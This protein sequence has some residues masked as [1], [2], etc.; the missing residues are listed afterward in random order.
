MRFKKI[1]TGKLDEISV[2]Y[3]VLR[4]DASTGETVRR[5]KSDFMKSDV[6]ETGITDHHKIIFPFSKNT[7]SEG[8][9]KTFFH[10]C[11]N[12]FDQ[13][14]FNEEY[15]IRY[16]TWLTISKYSWDIPV[17]VKIHLLPIRKKKIIYNKSFP[18]KNS[19]KKKKESKLMW[20][21]RN[22]LKK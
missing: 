2:F 6:Y 11:Y 16:T 18:D 9:P 20:K 8:K 12:K 13:K 10:P 5:S 3:A 15:Q 14:S 19:G 22:K 17:N 1:Y 21:V 7:F 4:L